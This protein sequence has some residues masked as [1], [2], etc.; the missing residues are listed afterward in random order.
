MTFGEEALAQEIDALGRGAGEGCR[1]FWGN[2]HDQQRP[3]G[4]PDYA[5]WATHHQ[6]ASG[7]R[8]CSAPPQG[9]QAFYCTQA[10]VWIAARTPIIEEALRLRQ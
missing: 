5:G 6:T 8:G 1:R 3:D 2:P 9:V 4:H 7:T 10:A